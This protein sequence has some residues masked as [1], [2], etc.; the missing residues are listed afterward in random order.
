LFPLIP[1][2]FQFEDE[3]IRKNYESESRW[4]KVIFFDAMLI[5]LIS[6]IGLFGLSILTAEKR[7]K[8]IGIRKVLGA[9]VRVINLTRTGTQ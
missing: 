1:F 5:T 4:K 7:F 3:L 2:D 9:S 8:E 6:A